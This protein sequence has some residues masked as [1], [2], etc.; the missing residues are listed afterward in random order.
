MIDRQGGFFYLTCDVYQQEASEAFFE[1]DE[2]VQYKKDYGWKSQRRN[3]EWED[4]CPEC[5]EVNANV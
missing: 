5:Q 1:F 3:G 4:V 2:A